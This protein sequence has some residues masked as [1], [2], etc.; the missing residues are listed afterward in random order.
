MKKV[1]ALLGLIA[2][3]GSWQTAKAKTLE[4]VLKE[5]GVITE[6]DFKEVQKSSPVKYKL[7]EGFNFTSA[8]GKFSSS[9]GAAFQVRYTLMDV[10][11]VNNSPAKQAQDS[12]KLELKRIKLL[13]NG[14][15]YSPDLTYKM[16]I[17]FAN[18]IG[19]TTTGSGLLEE[20]WMNYRLLDAVQ[21][22]F[23]QDKVPFARQ[24]MTPSTAQQFVDQSIVTA[25]FAPGYDTGITVLG[26]VAGGLFNYCIAGL[27]GVGQNTFRGT[28]DN[29]FV[30][31]ITADPFGYVKYSEADLDNSIKPLWSVGGSFYRNTVN[32]TAGAFESNNLGFAKST[33]WYGIGTPLMTAAQKFNTTEAID[34][35][36]YGVDTVFKWRG[37]SVTGEYFRGYAEGQTTTHKLNAEGFYGQA[38]YFILPKKVELAYR[39]SYL[40]PNQSTTKDHWTENTAAVSW[41]IN[42]HNLKLQADYTNVHKQSNIASVNSGPNAKAS[43]D[44][45]VRFQAQILF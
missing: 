21:F 15:A 13:F 42:N 33:G 39:Y 18:I 17:N 1:V 41:Y 28:T 11:D 36:T 4:E 30:A 8:D 31:R 22:R 12:S 27:G 35:N 10:D 25:A 45:Q 23:G 3:L 7:G 24:F 34:F 14:Y 9:I 19:N 38:G 5:K 37:L 29:A 6:E 40:D 20:T 2:V 26:K 43:D 32:Q 16:S 44:Q